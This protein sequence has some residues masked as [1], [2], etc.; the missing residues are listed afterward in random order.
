[1]TNKEEYEIK[2]SGRGADVQAENELWSMIDKKT[3]I[4]C[5]IVLGVGLFIIII[6]IIAKHRAKK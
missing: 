5:G 3:L 2:R 1:M 4:I 6:S